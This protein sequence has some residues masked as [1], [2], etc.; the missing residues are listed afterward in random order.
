MIFMGGRPGVTTLDRPVS[1]F[2]V[3]GIPREKWSSGLF[4]CFGNIF[5]SCICSF[6]CA[7]VIFGQLSVRA[8]IPLFIDVKNSLVGYGVSSGYCFF[9]QVLLW[10]VLITGGLI[11][12][13]ITM[14]GTL[15]MLFGLIAVGLGGLIIFLLSHLRTA[16]KQKYAID[17]PFPRATHGAWNC[18]FDLLV[19]VLCMPCSL[20]QM[21]RHVFQYDQW[22]PKIGALYCGDPAELPPLTN[23]V[24]RPPEADEAG[25]VNVDNFR[26]KNPHAPA[27]TDWN[28]LSINLGHD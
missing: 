24:N 7:P 25:L 10:S 11:Y 19:S 13:I 21:A 16:V 1:N 3:A 5:P 27:S 26:Y 28:N 8:Q 22:D 2:D 23:D 20:A 15:K 14:E 17:G 4:S 12:G 6:C 9:V 18:T